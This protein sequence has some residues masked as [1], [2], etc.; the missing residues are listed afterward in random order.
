[1]PI[2]VDRE[3]VRRLVGRGAVVVEVLGSKAY[4]GT[5]LPGAVNV[6]LG[7]VARRAPAELRRDG[8]VVVYCYDRQ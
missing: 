4:R 3:T 1:M 7:E 5:H 2:I 6:P 8:L